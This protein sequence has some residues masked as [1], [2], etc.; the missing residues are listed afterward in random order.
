MELRCWGTY[1]SPFPGDPARRRA[2]AQTAADS[3]RRLA[4]FRTVGGWEGLSQVAALAQDDAVFK[5][6]TTL[7]C[8]LQEEN[9]KCILMYSIYVSLAST[10]R[11]AGFCYP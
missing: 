10:Y 9:N 7:R 3:H 11:D 6:W 4:H 5:A 1:L 8:A 2:A